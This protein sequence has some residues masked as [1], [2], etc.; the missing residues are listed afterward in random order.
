VLRFHGFLQDLSF[1]SFFGAN[2]T[3]AIFYRH[4]VIHNCCFVAIFCTLFVRIAA[5][6]MQNYKIIIFIY[7]R[8][9]NRAKF[10]VILIYF[11]SIVYY[12]LNK[13]LTI[14]ALIN[15]N[16][17]L[18]PSLKWLIQRT[19]VLI[20]Y[21]LLSSL[22]SFIQ[23][24]NF[25]F[26]I[27]KIGIPNLSR[28]K[29]TTFVSQ[30]L[31]TFT[32]ETESS[33][34]ALSTRKENLLPFKCL[35]TKFAF[36]LVFVPYSFKGLLSVVLGSYFNYVLIQTSMKNNLNLRNFEVIIPRL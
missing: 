2:D 31:I 1:Y 12:V 28:A 14:F 24:L 6:I 3:V 8:K 19:L 17:I 5:V 27:L 23:D 16:C 4:L 25:L 9:A 13:P 7:F 26:K 11:F 32:I 33:V 20:L 21:L 35:L 10:D 36:V 18:K 34:I 29:R 22:I 30:N 15:L